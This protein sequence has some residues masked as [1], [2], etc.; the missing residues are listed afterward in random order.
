MNATVASK[1]KVVSN[2]NP[3]YRKAVSN[4]TAPLKATLMDSDSEVTK[5]ATKSYAAKSGSGMGRYL[6]I[7]AAVVLL[8][9]ISGLAYRY[10]FKTTPTETPQPVQNIT[11]DSSNTN[12]AHTT[13]TNQETKS[14]SQPTEQRKQQTTSTTKTNK[15][16]SNKTQSDN[17]PQTSD[18]SS[19]PSQ[20]KPSDGEGHSTNNTHDSRTPAQQPGQYPGSMTEAE[21]QRI[22][23]ERRKQM[24]R[25]K[26]EMMRRRQ[27][28]PVKR[29]LQ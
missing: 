16:D 2:P 17:T 29:P 1:P 27:N 8:L 21:R 22:E 9:G 18:T 4:P 12:T 15:S 28:P 13:N 7:A 10:A 20:T 11:V 6:G 3:S 19:Q 24:M 14:T 23:A 5:L 25:R 26:I